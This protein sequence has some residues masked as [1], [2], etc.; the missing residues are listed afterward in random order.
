MQYSVKDCQACE[1]HAIDYDLIVAREVLSYR[2]VPDL[3]Q[4]RCPRI[5]PSIHVVTL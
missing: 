1:V 3:R 5:M 4:R 2:Y